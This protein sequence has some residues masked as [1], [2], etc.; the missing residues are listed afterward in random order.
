MSAPSPKNEYASTV[1]A[2]R[3]LLAGLVLAIALL[4]LAGRQVTRHSYHPGFTRFFPHISP[5]ASYYP[6]V[7]EM[8]AIVRDKCRP[9]QI[10]VIVGGNS[11]LYGVG[12]APGSVWTDHLQELLGPGFC[13][14]NFAFRGASAADGGAII[15]EVLRKEFPRQVY[16]ANN[17]PVNPIDPVGA[18]PF[19][20]ITWEA[21]FKGMLEKYPPRDERF[22]RFF[23]SPRENPPV[24]WHLQVAA[25]TDQVLRYRDF[26]NW[27][28]FRLIATVPNAS[29]ATLAGALAPRGSYADP[30]PNGALIPMEARFRP[31]YLEAEMAIVRGFTSNAYIKGPEGEWQ[32]HPGVLKGFN[33]FVRSAM[34]PELARRTLMVL[35]T[36]SPYYLQML[37]QDELKREKLAYRDSETLW[38]NAGYN[39]ITY[40]PTLAPEDFLD[41]TH[42]LSSGGRKLAELLAPEVVRISKERG[43]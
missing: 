21:Y 17:S 11:I 8:C 31:A 13:V 20:F 26:W 25:R 40:G 1:F 14:V 12:Q 19:R 38:R 7:A 39:A 28:D 23:N 4:A 41:R 24:K 9:D 42:L 6:T 34:P 43:Y 30:E 16:I 29:A 35:S 37:D 32:L 3:W 15:A 5:E 2:P 18:A 33:D 10:L 27:V 36:N 22:E